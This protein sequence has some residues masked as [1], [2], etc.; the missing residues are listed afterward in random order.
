M[1][2]IVNTN[3]TNLRLCE[4]RVG[5]FNTLRVSLPMVSPDAT[6][7]QLLL[8]N[9]TIT[10][11]Y[12]ATKNTDGVWIC[13]V[14]AAQ[15][16][17]FGK[18]KYEVAYKLDNK[19]FWDGQ[20]WVNVVP[21]TTSGIVPQPIPPPHRWAIISITQG[22][23]TH[24]ADENGDINLDDITRVR[25]DNVTGKPDFADVATS[26][27]YNDLKDVPTTFPPEAHTH[28]KSQITDFPVPV[29]PS[30]EAADGAF[31]AAKS[32]A[33]FVNSS[34]NNLAAY[35]LTYNAQGD[36]FPTK[37]ALDAATTFYNGGVEREPTKND[38]LIIL[39]DE[40]H[41]TALGVNP[42]TRYVYDGAQWAFQYVVNNTSL[43]QAQ[44]DAINS[45]ITPVLVNWLAAF[46]GNDTTT[47]LAA[48][49][50]A[51]GGKQAQLNATQLNAVNS[52]ITSV[53]VAW[54]ST[55]KGSDDNTTLAS[56]LS[57]LAEKRDKTDFVIVPETKIKDEY[58]PITGG[59]YDW[60][61][62][63][64]EKND[65]G[66]Y[67][68]YDSSGSSWAAMF[69]AD[70]SLTS[71]DQ[72]Y[73]NGVEAQSLFGEILIDIADNIARESQLEVK[74][75]KTELESK[76]NLTDLPYKYVFRSIPTSSSYPF[77]ATNRAINRIYSSGYTHL[78]TNPT[79]SLPIPE[80]KKIAECVLRWDTGSTVNAPTLV[81]PSGK[82]AQSYSISGDTVEANAKYE[83]FIQIMPTNTRNTYEVISV[84]RKLA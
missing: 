82:T 70:G 75:D 50:T 84:I 6:D 77:F 14:A 60:S 40:E 72:I 20:G 21:A 49:Q 7:V 34:I 27:S 42:T 15:F 45:G 46:K 47:T 30:T 41:T 43:T 32:V 26:G 5:L 81:L 39:E 68:L 79:V 67:Y 78:K 38:Y 10:T 19:Q 8:T 2:N 3:N 53:L 61:S 51:I 76:A 63:R 22:D 13:D 80:T 9:G 17:S 74:A 37:A 73:F 11:A 66:S 36:A 52:G 29:M 35:Y 56:V 25:W 33:E 54:L 57:T 18:Q 83:M 28:T 58:L 44:V 69:N 64:L 71:S 12:S 62:Y 48:L 59:S 24:Y 23:I 16:S 31:A 65:D 1:E 55:F 4:L